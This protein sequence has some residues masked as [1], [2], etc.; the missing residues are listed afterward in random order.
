MRFVQ[1]EREKLKEM[2][3]DL[4]RKLR[5]VEAK[6]REMTSQCN[7][8]DEP[9]HKMNNWLDNSFSAKEKKMKTSNSMSNL[10]KTK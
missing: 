6:A 1:E 10:A 7:Q 4:L 3:I 9:L 5:I 8:E 2:E